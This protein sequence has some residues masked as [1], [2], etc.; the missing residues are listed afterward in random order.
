MTVIKAR[1][2]LLGA[3]QA[4]RERG[5]APPGA[6][7][8]SVYRVRGCSVVIDDQIEWLEGARETVTVPPL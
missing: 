5:I 8:G 2:M 6:R 1:Q 3:A 7:D 4:W